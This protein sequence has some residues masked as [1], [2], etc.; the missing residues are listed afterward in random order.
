M[1]LYLARW[2]TLICIGVSTLLSIGYIKLMDKFAFTMAWISVV[3]VE[4]GLILAGIIA[5]MAKNDALVDSYM[6][7]GGDVSQ[8]EVAGY[9]AVYWCSWIA[10]G[11]YL[12]FA[13]CSFHSLRISIKIVEVASDFYSDTKRAVL[14]PL[15]Y[16]TIA[17]VIFVCWMFALACVCSLGEIST[18]SVLLQSKDVERSSLNQGMIA[19]MVIGMIW[20]VEFLAA[21]NQFVIIC[22]AA[23]WYFDPIDEKHSDMWI[24][25]LW[26]CGKN[27]GTIALGSFIMTLVDI[28]R[29]TF[30]YLG[31]KIE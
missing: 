20:I 12:L 6:Y 16:F 9:K 24:G 17:I 19:L 29:G 4:I 14:I 22:A 1:E 21:C 8:S 28:I 7:G 26:A 3:F 13:I 25:M 2:I 10:A 11:F 31:N 30:E 23:D 27:I 18:E 15:M 5:Y